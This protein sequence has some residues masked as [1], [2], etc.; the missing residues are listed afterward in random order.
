MQWL[1][2]LGWT[3]TTPSGWI[4]WH[5]ARWGSVGFGASSAEL[6]RFNIDMYNKLRTDAASK[7][8]RGKGMENG[9]EYNVA[10]CILRNKKIQSKPQLSAV[11]RQ[12][13]LVVLVPYLG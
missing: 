1:L 4:D 5:K 2:Y 7:R 10:F 11:M 3:P 13:L 9:I 8:Y 6:V 12:F